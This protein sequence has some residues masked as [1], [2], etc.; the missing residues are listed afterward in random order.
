MREI[1]ARYLM[2]E[3][4][5][6]DVEIAFF[7]FK[8]NGMEIDFHISVD[9]TLALDYLFAEDG[10]L[11]IGPPKAIF[12]DLH[13]PKMSGLEFLRIIKAN[14]QSNNIPIVVLLSSNSPAELDECKRLG[15]K[16]FIHKPLGYENFIGAI[17]DID[18]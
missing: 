6:S 7:D 4:N 15:V 11:R 18:K 13:M 14:Q 8:E 9:P 2:I 3:D 10:F 1:R 12:L 5:G 16:W 17:R